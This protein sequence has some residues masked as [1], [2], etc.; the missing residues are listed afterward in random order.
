MLIS[1][2]NDARNESRR[3]DRIDS[4]P[5]SEAEGEYEF[6]V[7]AAKEA[8][9]RVSSSEGI[10]GEKQSAQEGPREGNPQ[11]GQVVVVSEDSRSGMLGAASSAS[12]SPTKDR[13]RQRLSSLIF[14][15][16]N[17]CQNRAFYF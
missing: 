15:L 12:R 10:E 3:D 16:R 6:W 9:E 17:N 5:R 4:R 1:S 13:F 2:P 11:V 7:D 8:R 14:C